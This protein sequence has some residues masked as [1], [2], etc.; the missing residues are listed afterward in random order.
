MFLFFCNMISV[1]TPMLA[2]LPCFF[3]S[4]QS[5][6]SHF[7]LSHFH[8]LSSFSLHNTSELQFLVLQGS[9]YSRC[10]KLSSFSP[11]GILFLLSI[12]AQKLEP[13]LCWPC[14]SRSSYLPT[15]VEYYSTVEGSGYVSYGSYARAYKLYSRRFCIPA[16][17][18]FA[19]HQSFCLVHF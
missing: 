10:N 15:A 12:H 14:R 1:A 4:P 7:F 11:N 6:Y 17:P 5:S 13:F 9:N 16:S 19:E 3:A 2:G 18:F 8:Y